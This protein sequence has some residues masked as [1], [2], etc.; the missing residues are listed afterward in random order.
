MLVGSTDQLVARGELT[1]DFSAADE[2][3]STCAAKF[4]GIVTGLPCEDFEHRFQEMNFSGKIRAL[5]SL[6]Q[7]CSDAYH[8][9]SGRMLNLLEALSGTADHR[10]DIIHGWVEWDPKRG[11]PVFKNKNK[12]Y[13][14]A[15]TNEIRKLCERLSAWLDDFRDEVIRFLGRVQNKTRT[16][17]NAAE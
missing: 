1:L 4:V 11:R 15:A 9:E 5:R 17:Q 7:I 2:A 3:V 12:P 6:I 13:R 8:V 16:P 10:N 14:S